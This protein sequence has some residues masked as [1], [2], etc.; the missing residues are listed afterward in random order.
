M[1]PIS[2]SPPREFHIMMSNDVDHI[3]DLLKPPKRRHAEA[4][5]YLRTL[6]V[7]EQVAA[8][9]VAEI[10]QPTEYELERIATQLT[11]KDW[12]RY[13]QVLPA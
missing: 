10:R 5:A 6:M 9:P 8:D 12:T 13:C 3:R 1:L 7:S 2:V 11:D 4:L